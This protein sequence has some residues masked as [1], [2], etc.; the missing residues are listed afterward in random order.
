VPSPLR[1]RETSTPLEPTVIRSGRV[2]LTS[3]VPKSAKNSV[4]LWYWWQ[5]QPAL[6]S[7]SGLALDALDFHHTPGLG[8]HWPAST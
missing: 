6:V 2:S 3:Y 5:F 4:A 8:N 7:G 1:V